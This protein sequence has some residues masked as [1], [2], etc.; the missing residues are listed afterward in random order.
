MDSHSIKLTTSEI[1]GLWTTY[2]QNSAVICVFKYFLTY[3]QDSEIKQVVDEALKL[4][5]SHLKQIEDIFMEGNIPVPMGFSDKDVDL[6]APPLYTELYTLS[7][8]YRFGQ[9]N[10]HHFGLTAS[11]VARD[12]VAAFFFTGLDSVT[13][14]YKMSLELMLAK[15]IYDRPPKIT[16][17]E[18]AEIIQEQSY[19]GKW[20]GKQRALNVME[21]GEIFFVIER[22]Y[23]GLL[24]LYGFIQVVKDKEVKQYLIRG[25][26]LSEKQI[27]IF[28]EL[29]RKEDLLEISPV[30]MEVTNSTTAPFSDKLIMFLI[31]ATTATSVPLLAYAMSVTNRKD[32]TAHYPGIIAE[33]M[34]FGE[35]GINIMI[36]RGWVEQPP[37][38]FNRK[39]F[40]KDNR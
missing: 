22:N 17:P 5:Q 6:A 18:K 35:D 12:D 9:I 36:N 21:L 39:A 32:V 19:L 25:K 33:I 4:S 20:F 7:F 10:L 2:I 26:E 40:M 29:L 24:L 1:S 27:N 16:Y 37:L 3:I 23:I 31:T 28:N 15:G 8:V 38:A 11:K 13:K 14:L 30:T 34:L